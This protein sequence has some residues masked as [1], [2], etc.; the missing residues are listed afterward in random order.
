MYPRRMPQL[1]DRAADC[2][3]YMLAQSVLEVGFPLGF[4]PRVQSALRAMIHPHKD[5]RVVILTT[6]G[7]IHARVFLHGNLSVI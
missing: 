5:P 1:N 3:R 6:A 2:H 7:Q 4:L